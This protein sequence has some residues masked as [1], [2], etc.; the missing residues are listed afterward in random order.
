MNIK[1]KNRFYKNTEDER[2][3]LNKKDQFYK[4]TEEKRWI[5][6]KEGPIL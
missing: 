6:S 4:K 3:I 2:W 5:L 1:P